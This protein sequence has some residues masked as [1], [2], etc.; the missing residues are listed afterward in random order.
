MMLAGES[1][2]GGRIRSSL[3]NHLYPKAPMFGVG[4]TLKPSGRLMM[5]LLKSMPR[6]TWRFMGAYNLNYHCTSKHAKSSK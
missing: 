3:H 2:I 4:T 5:R 6:D 1:A